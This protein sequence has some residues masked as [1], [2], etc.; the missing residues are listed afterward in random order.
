MDLSR[1]DEHLDAAD[2]DGYLLD[3]DSTDPSQYYLSGFDAPDPFVTL[4]T[5]AQTAILTSPLE[6]ARAKTE[7]RADAVRRLGD[8][9]YREKRAEHG[10][11]Q[12]RSM[13]LAEFLAEFDVTAVGTNRRFPLFTADSLRD[14]QVTVQA[15]PDDVIEEIR[16]T[17]TEQELAHIREAQSANEAAMEAAEAMIADAEVGSDGDLQLD[18]EVLTSERVK[19]TIERTL[20]DRG[21]A[22]DD[23]IV[24][25]GQTGANPHDSG[26]GPIGVDEPII[27]DIFPQSKTTKYHAD[28]TRTFLK[29]EPTAE[30]AD[31]YET[32]KRAKAAALET[33]E[34]G[35]TGADVHDAV[36]DVYENAG[37]PTL[38]EDES[39]ETGF[40]HG[41]GHGVGLA[42]HEQP[43]I[44]PDGGELEAGQVITI[45][46]GLYDPAV[47]G[48]RIEDL[49]VVT[50]DGYENLTDY[51][52]TL[53]V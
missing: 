27:V 9:D 29:G 36:C 53:V 46:P 41:T 17:K 20:L 8:Y 12:A 35:V 47:G 39:T 14:R 18:G 52:E 6:Y 51:S 23:T 28:M 2:L 19:A 22:L 21:F 49:V 7:S 11:E 16:A 10:R 37:Y 32:T 30:V 43:Q 50:E 42:V 3:A 24:A 44:S 38:R 4:Y 5:P 13:V 31:F 1:L 34:A 45:E 26:S 33:V 48:V 25:S 15:D 40:I